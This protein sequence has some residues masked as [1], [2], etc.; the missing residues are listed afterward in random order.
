M[1]NSAHL[2]GADNHT[3]SDPDRIAFADGGGH[4]DA[5][6]SADIDGQP[7]PDGNSQPCGK[8]LTA[9]VRDTYRLPQRRR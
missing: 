9:T 7:E 8:H 1:H 2:A 3:D 6:A 4:T 5:D